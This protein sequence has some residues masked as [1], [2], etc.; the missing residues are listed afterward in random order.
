M[1][2]L[3]H[4]SLGLCISKKYKFV[5]RT[6]CHCLLILICFSCFSLHTRLESWRS[7][8]QDKLQFREIPK[9]HKFNF[10]SQKCAFYILLCI[11]HNLAT[12]TVFVT[13]NM[14]PGCYLIVNT[15]FLIPLFCF[16]HGF[17]F[18]FFL[19]T[20]TNIFPHR[21]IIKLAQVLFWYEN[22]YR[23]TGCVDHSGS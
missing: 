16:Q 22:S 7:T 8:L 14:L 13:S 20:G 2:V 18:L 5:L 1:H 17:L 21:A 23:H 6:T 9:K 3:V 12:P 11:F 15:C 10:E 19:K 4:K